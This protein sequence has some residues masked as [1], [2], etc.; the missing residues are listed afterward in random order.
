MS[1]N[2]YALA[3]SIIKGL[4]PEQSF[5]LLST[6]RIKQKCNL[7]DTED[8]IKLKDQGMTYAE[9]GEVFGISASAAYRR[10]NRAK[11]RLQ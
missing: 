2:Y 11:R 6:G 1:E 10:I 9:L 3:I 4:P 7:E 8:L 5:E